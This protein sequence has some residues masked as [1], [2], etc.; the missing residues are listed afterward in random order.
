MRVAV[1]VNG[2]T[3]QMEI[4]RPTNLVAPEE[5]QSVLRAI[6]RWERPTT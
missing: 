5:R 4:L 1:P 2:G 3:E 6:E